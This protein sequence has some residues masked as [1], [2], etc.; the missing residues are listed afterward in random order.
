M[1]A[2]VGTEEI[3]PRRTFPAVT[4]LIVAINILVFLY[5]AFILLTEGEEGLN[6]M[7]QAVAL[8]PGLVTE[9][10]SVVLPFYLTFF[11]AMFV[12]GGLLHIASNMIYLVVF[13]DNVEDLMG[14]VL[15]IF[16]YLLCG[17][18][19]SV[20]QIAADP[21]S[22]IPNVGA[23]GAIAGVLAG[24]L[25]L[26]PTGTVRI[27]FFLPPFSRIAR[28][29]ALFFISLWFILQIFGG[30]MSLGASSESGGVAY[31]AHVGGF[32]AG[33]ALAFVYKQIMR[34]RLAWT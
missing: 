10:Q 29:P 18:A 15:Y 26:L 25:L 33:L 23:S 13:G 17:L 20:A 27:L 28:I 8:V 16:F 22:M 31:W 11:T 14:P 3:I 6:A 32:L 19:A 1:F 4:A 9:G 12:H 2:P 34:W 7:I 5:Q 30:A 24:Y 21:T